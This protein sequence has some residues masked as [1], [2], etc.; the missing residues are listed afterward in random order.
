M[1]LRDDEA[2][3]PSEIPENITIQCDDEIPAPP[4]ITGLDNC[5]DNVNVSFTETV[6]GQFCPYVITRTWTLEDECGN[7]AQVEQTITVVTSLNVQDIA[8]QAI[9]NP[10]DGNMTIMFA[11][12]EDGFVLLE[13]YNALGERLEIIYNGYALGGI[14]YEIKVDGSQWTDGVYYSRLLMD[15]ISKTNRIMKSK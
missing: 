4:Q 8:M 9:P 13:I 1:F 12:P 6:S 10:F 14:Q 3:V 15:D 7:E 2:P 11:L 5:D